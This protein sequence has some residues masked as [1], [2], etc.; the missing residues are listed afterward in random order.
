MK[1]LKYAC[2]MIVQSVRVCSTCCRKKN[3]DFFSV[4][5]C[6]FS[7]TFKEDSHV[8]NKVLNHLHKPIM[9]P[10]KF[11]SDLGC[12]KASEFMRFFFDFFF[13]TL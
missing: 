10:C 4:F 5:C 8:K 13:S 3:V 11:K 2:L 7:L 9:V 12:S 1:I 6:F